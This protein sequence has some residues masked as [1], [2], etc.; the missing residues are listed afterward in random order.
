MATHSSYFWHLRATPAP[1]WTSGPDKCAPKVPDAPSVTVVGGRGAQREKT[2]TIPGGDSF[3]EMGQD[4]F[5]S[6]GDL[7]ASL[8]RICALGWRS[9]PILDVCLHR[10]PTYF[11]DIRTHYGAPLWASVDPR[12][13]GASPDL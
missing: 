1:L 5:G 4:L 8:P 9:L 10:T 13:E 6:L 2:K 11:M 12:F 3:Q 7:T